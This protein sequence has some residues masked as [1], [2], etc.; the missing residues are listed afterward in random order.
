M[1]FDADALENAFAASGN[2]VRW[3]KRCEYSESVQRAEIEAVAD[4]HIGSFLR[5]WGE[6]FST[7]RDPALSPTQNAQNYAPHLMEPLMDMYTDF[8]KFGMFMKH[9]GF[10]EENEWRASF[11]AQEQAMCS[12]REGIHGLVPFLPIDV[13]LS[14]S[15]KR[16]VV[17]PGPQIDEWVTTVRLMLAK[18]DIAG[19]EVLPSKIPYRNW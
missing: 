16:V 5:V 3:F 17:G 2:V 14:K 9:H 8:V 10:R 7:L 19:V 13:D 15:L 1:G 11:V 4:R 6:C 12:F 18:C